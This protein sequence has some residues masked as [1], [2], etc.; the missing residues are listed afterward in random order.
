MR[1]N[2]AAL[3][4]LSRF[5]SI[6][7]LRAAKNLYDFFNRVPTAVRSW[8][9][10]QFLDFAKITDRLHLPAIQA[11]DE[12]VLDRDDLQ[13]PFVSGRQIKRKR[14]VFLRTFVQHADEPRYLRPGR[15][16]REQ[17]LA[18][19]IDNRFCGTNHDLAFERQFLPDRGTQ[20]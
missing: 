11:D 14:K 12:F 18:R 1:S 7:V 8:N 17:I 6:R 20:S 10:K 2:S 5:K 3:E 9:A 15:L 16:S 13:E 19:K 4:K